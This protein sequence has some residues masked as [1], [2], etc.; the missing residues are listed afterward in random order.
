MTFKSVVRIIIDVVMT[1]LMILSLAY[2]ITG[3]VYHEWIGITVSMLF[4]IHNLLNLHWYKNI[5]KGK[6]NFCRSINTM[7]NLLLIIDMTALLI[8]G[9][10]HSRV[11]L[12]FLHL[13]TGIFIRQIH[14]L[15]AYWGLV[16]V[17]FH[18][19][20]H[21][22]MVLNVFK[23]A[24][25]ISNNVFILKIISRSI[26]AAIIVYGVISS[27]ERDMYAKLFLNYSFDFWPPEKPV[28]LFCIN[29]ISIM[30]IYIF[31]SYFL[32]KFTGRI[33]KGIRSFNNQK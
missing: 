32:I 8:T 18:I 14:T 12:S 20:Q 4:I 29:N 25:K 9:M 6:Y 7:I 19:G 26:A 17:S 16:L 27:F 24:F 21:W 30:S 2:R 1:I 3:N 33:K 11:L 31:I 10:L 15:S 23:K 28:I 5:F 22:E 13:N